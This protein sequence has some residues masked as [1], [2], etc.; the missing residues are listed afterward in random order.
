MKL[1][2]DPHRKGA[3][4]IYIIS[5]VAG[6]VYGALMGGLKYIALWRKI[7]IAGPNEEITA[8][9]IYIRMPIDY[10]INVMTFVILFL[11]RNIILPLDFAVTAI[12]AAVS[13]SLIGRV[14]SIRKVF[15]KISA[16]TGAEEKTND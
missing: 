4:L 10:G 11:V 3:A 5:A 6:L 2:G 9:A 16:E 7:I 12:A 15:D 1:A 8:R 14:F 13:L